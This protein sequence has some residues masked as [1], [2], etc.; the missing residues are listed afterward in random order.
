[1]FSALECSDMELAVVY[2]NVCLN[3]VRIRLY[4]YIITLY[5]NKCI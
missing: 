1:M 3:N 2:Q 4:D 5:D